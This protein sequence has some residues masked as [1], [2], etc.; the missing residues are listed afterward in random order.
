M[1]IINMKENAIYITPINNNLIENDNISLSDIVA[2]YK[3]NGSDAINIG[4]PSVISY[5]PVMANMYGF[6]DALKKGYFLQI[7]NDQLNNYFDVPVFKVY[8]TNVQTVDTSLSKCVNS[9][10]YYIENVLDGEIIVEEY[11]MAK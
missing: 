4:K 9:E 1:S 3:V 11:T 6:N 5:L 10:D 2:L 7:P 8:I